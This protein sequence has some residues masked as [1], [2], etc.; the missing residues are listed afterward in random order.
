MIVHSDV[1]RALSWD[2]L[3]A[4]NLGLFGGH[5]W[6]ELKDHLDVLGKDAEKQVD[7]QYV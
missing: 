6:K 1:Y 4:Y 2:C 3:H 5:L 7:D